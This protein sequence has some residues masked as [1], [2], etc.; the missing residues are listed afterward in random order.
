MPRPIMPVEALLEITTS[1]LASPL[2]LA[3]AIEAGLPVTA[4]DQL[5]GV[6]APDDPQFKYRIIPKT[7][8]QRRR[9]SSGRLTLEEGDRLARLARV[10]SFALEIYGS[11][12]KARAFLR[13]SHPMLGG[14]MPL[15]VALTTDPGADLVINLVGR[16]A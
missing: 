6:L 9:K 4:L 1:A 12:D 7:T 11:A 16:A 13:R 5:V 2:P 15:D 14:Q 8:L 10:F 3:H